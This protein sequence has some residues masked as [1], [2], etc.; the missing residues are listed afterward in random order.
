MPSKVPLYHPQGVE[1]VEFHCLWAKGS[2]GM[3]PTEKPTRKCGIFYFFIFFE[4]IHE[5][6]TSKACEHPWFAHWVTHRWK[7][8]CCF[9]DDF[10]EGGW[11]LSLQA[12]EK[13]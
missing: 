4:G 1:V 2:L 9:L 12:R 11:D 7:Q 10:D 3:S 13:D 6:Q 5:L 8:K